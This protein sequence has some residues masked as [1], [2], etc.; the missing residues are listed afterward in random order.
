MGR[1]L[2]GGG[3]GGRAVVRRRDHSLGGKEVVVVV[4]S[5]PMEA[6]RISRVLELAK[7]VWRRYSQAKLPD[8]CLKVGATVMK[9]GPEMEKWARMANRLVRGEC[10]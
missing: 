10:L 5:S 4:L 8:W 3:E 2:W 1:G 6:A 9:S 7:E